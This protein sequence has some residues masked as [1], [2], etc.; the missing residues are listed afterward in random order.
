M[1]HQP[2]LSQALE[3][4]GL[5]SVSLAHLAAGQLQ[6]WLQQAFR[7]A[8]HFVQTCGLAVDTPLVGVVHSAL[9]HLAGVGTKRDFACGLFRGLGANVAE[10]GRQGLAAEVGKLMS[11]PNVLMG[12][13]VAD[14]AALL[15]YTDGHACI[16]QTSS[17]TSIAVCF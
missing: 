13:S 9:S 17:I 4:C 6:Q 2:R 11:E 7:P 5:T 8:L 14:P 15:R 12:S 16:I 1:W 10:A 3:P